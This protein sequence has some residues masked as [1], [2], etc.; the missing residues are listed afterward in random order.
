MT[1]E[2]ETGDWVEDA[3]E[4]LTAIAGVR[5]EPATGDLRPLYLAWLSAYPA[6][7]N[8][9]TAP[10]S[11]TGSPLDDPATAHLPGPD[12]AIAGSGQG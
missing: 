9:S 3:E 1:S 7:S 12:P 2:D 4:S 11:P 5:S 10:V 6:S 8:D